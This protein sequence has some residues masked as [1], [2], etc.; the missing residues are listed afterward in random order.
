MVNIGIE[1]M[2]G[3]EHIYQLIVT[4]EDNNFSAYNDLTRQGCEVFMLIYS[5]DS[6]ESFEYLAVVRQKIEQIR[7]SN[8]FLWW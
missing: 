7:Q 8:N 6:P 4:S 1:G 2:K 5:V 3:E